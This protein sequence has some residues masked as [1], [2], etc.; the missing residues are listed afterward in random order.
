[1]AVEVDEFDGFAGAGESG[2]DDDL[3][4]RGEGDD[5]AVVVGVEFEVEQDDA[6][7]GADG[8]GDG[9]DGGAVAAFGEIGDALYESA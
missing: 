1:M 7:Q 5:A 9:F 6:G 8:G 2:F 3:R 4:G